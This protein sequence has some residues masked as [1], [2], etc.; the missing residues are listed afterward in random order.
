MLHGALPDAPAGAK[1]GIARLPMRS[2]VA[3]FG[4]LNEEALESP[5]WGRNDMMQ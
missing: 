2:I 3:E 5:S 1:S 4:V